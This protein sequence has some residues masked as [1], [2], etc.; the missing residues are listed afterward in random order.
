[1]SLENSTTMKLSILAR[2]ESR[3]D[4][5]RIGNDFLQQ[6]EGVSESK[7]NR[8]YAPSYRHSGVGGVGMLRSVI[9][10][11]REILTAFEVNETTKTSR[12]ASYGN[13]ECMGNCKEVGGVH[14]SVDVSVMEC[15]AKEPYLVDVNRERKDM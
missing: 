9:E 12:V 5:V 2:C 3:R 8:C 11:N 10:T 14:S 1:M 15:G 7:Y 6:K 4:S 13:S